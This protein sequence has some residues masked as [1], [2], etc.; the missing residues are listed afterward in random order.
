MKTKTTLVVF[1][2]IQILVIAEGTFFDELSAEFKLDQILQDPLGKE[3]FSNSFV[4]T[5]NGNIDRIDN[6]NILEQA[7]TNHV[8]DDGDE[9]DDEKVDETLFLVTDCVIHGDSRENNQTHPCTLFEDNVL[10]RCYSISCPVPL[11][12]TATCTCQA[13]LDKETANLLHHL[14]NLFKKKMC[15][16]NNISLKWFPSYCNF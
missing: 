9:S 16:Q 4:R 7:N 8:H 11:E 12:R 3:L 1:L 2:C 10:D 5:E 15:L 6:Q 13:F 14:Y